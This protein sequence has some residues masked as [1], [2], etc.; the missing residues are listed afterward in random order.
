MSCPGYQLLYVIYG[1]KSEATRVILL[2]TRCRS[3]S[4]QNRTWRAGK[5]V[6]CDV[7]LYFQDRLPAR[8]SAGIREMPS[9]GR[10]V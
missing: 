8:T 9:L 7:F 1:S 10:I 3:E 6:R 2:V 5:K 4:G